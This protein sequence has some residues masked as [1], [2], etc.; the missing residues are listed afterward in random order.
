MRAYQ[1]EIIFPER[2]WQYIPMMEEIE[3]KVKLHH[4]DFIELLTK[5]VKQWNNQDAKDKLEDMKKLYT[6]QTSI[7][8]TISDININYFPYLDEYDNDDDFTAKLGRLDYI[9][10]QDQN[11][12]AFRDWYYNKRYII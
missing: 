2:L 4:E 1:S 12:D 5:F 11:R 3:Y 10:T 9:F 8:E 6:I 7:G